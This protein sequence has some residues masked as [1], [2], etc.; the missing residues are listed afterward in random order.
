MDFWTFV[1]MLLGQGVIPAG[2]K[3]MPTILQRK[4]I[5]SPWVTP[6]NKRDLRRI[7]PAKSKSAKSRCLSPYFFETFG[8]SFPYLK[9][10]KEKEVEMLNKIRSFAVAMVGGAAFVAAEFILIRMAVL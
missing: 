4:A 8:L 3:P 10:R 1:L 6:S 9:M 5:G 7:L 2:Q